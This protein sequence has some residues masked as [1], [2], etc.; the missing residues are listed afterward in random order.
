MPFLSVPIPTTANATKNINLN[1]DVQFA[2]DV[3]TGG[4]PKTCQTILQRARQEG[5]PGFFDL[6]KVQQMKENFVSLRNQLTDVNLN[7]NASI[8][9][10]E[11]D[12][13][14]E[15]VES[16][17]LPIL[18]LVKNCLT[19]ELKIDQ[20]KLKE[21]QQAYDTSKARYESIDEEHESVGYY[22]S[23][24]PLHRHVKE[25]NLFLLFGFSIFFLIISILTFLQI[26]GIEL[27]FILPKFESE[28]GGSMFSFS[29]D[30]YYQYLIGGL[31]VG[32]L[33]T[34]IGLWRKWF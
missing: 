30:N 33:Y 9:N 20:S 11:L 31:I 25:N 34:A 23:W 21:A 13:Y 7:T 4:V 14:L 28:F 15:T 27:K 3:G 5:K 6:Y 26:G 17:Q 19:E 16:T 8:T 1:T 10:P 2:V 22:E 29:I 18:R 12:E 24:L 32:V